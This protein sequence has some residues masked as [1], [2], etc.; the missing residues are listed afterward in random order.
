MKDLKGLN[1]D[2]STQADSYRMMDFLGS[3]FG[4]V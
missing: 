3:L 2:I 1:R 4:S